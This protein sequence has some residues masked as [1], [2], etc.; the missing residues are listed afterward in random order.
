MAK[1]LVEPREGHLTALIR[2][3][4]Y[5]KRHLQSKIIIDSL[6]RPWDHL[7][8]TSKDWSK[9][10]PDIKGEISPPD[11]PEPRGRPV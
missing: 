3:F 11:V 8:W 1:F 4:T 9:F 5:V 7:D 6:I 10:Y 2:G